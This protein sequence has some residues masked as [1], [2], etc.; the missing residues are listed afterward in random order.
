M[1]FI[2]KQ[3]SVIAHSLRDGG[4]TPKSAITDPHFFLVETLSCGKKATVSCSS[5]RH[6]SARVDE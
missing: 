2:W 3:S 1:R 6:S 4:G 5:K